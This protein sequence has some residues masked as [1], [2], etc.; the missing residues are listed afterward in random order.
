MLFRSFLMM[1]ILLPV[2]VFLQR[3]VSFVLV[4]RLKDYIY[5]RI[6]I[7]FNLVKIFSVYF[8]FREGQYLVVEYFLFITFMTI[9]GSCI[10]IYTTSVKIKYSFSRLLKLLRL[11]REYFKLSKELALS[12][13][14]LTIA[15]ILYYEMDLLII[16]WL[17]SMQDVAL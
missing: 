16:G 7:V 14:I 12:S 10:A 13:F 6:D 8:F 11:R 17:F 5:L 1:G 4:I 2:Q 9:I 3:L 15:F